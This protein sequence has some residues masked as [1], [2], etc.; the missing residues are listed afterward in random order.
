M[1]ATGVGPILAATS[2]RFRI[3]LTYPDTVSIG[4]RVPQIEA[5][6]FTMEYYIVSHAHQ[7]IAAEGTGLIVCFDYNKNQKAAL[8]DELK[9]RIEKLEASI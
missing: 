1:E 4:S 2:C 5:D 8:P 3:P 7:K 6:R 9:R